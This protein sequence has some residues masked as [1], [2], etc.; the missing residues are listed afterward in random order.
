MVIPKKGIKMTISEK[1]HKMI[2]N[3]VKTEAN[4]MLAFNKSHKTVQ[5]WIKNNKP[6]LTTS[7]AIKVIKESTGLTEKQIL[8]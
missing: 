4:L 6:M 5:R 8:A 7:T 3:D 2:L 1:A